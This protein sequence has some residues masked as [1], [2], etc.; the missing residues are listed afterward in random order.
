LTELFGGD[1]IKE[2][3]KNIRK[4]NTLKDSTQ[5]KWAYV[6]LVFSIGKMVS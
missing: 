3:K 6:V 5:P 2:M 4:I 1:I